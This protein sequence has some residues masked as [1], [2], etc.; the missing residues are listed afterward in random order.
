MN[1]RLRIRHLILALALCGGAWA[2]DTV[3]R[4]FSGVTCIHHEQQAPEPLAW[5]LVRVDLANPKIRFIT[6]KSNGDAPRDTRTQTT[7]EFAKET[8]AQIAINAN[9]FTF[10]GDANTDLLGLAVSEGT[11]VSPWD[12]SGS[13]CAVNISKD[14]KVTFINRVQESGTNTQP[15][16]TLYNA[17]SGRYWLVKDNKVVPETGGER[18][19]R[20]AIGRSATNELLMLIVDGRSGNHSVGMTIRELADATKTL[21]AVEAIALDGGGSATLVLADPLP[22]VLNVPMPLQAPAGMPATPPGIQRENGNNLAVFA[23][24]A[25]GAAP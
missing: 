8:G 12:N 18:H 10:D 4:P 6:T 22:H 16:V 1:L 20:T 19:P 7:L 5:F 23:A 15:P 9:Y 3:T 11:V 17:V 21:G 25:E 14:N 2:Q 24:P 13:A